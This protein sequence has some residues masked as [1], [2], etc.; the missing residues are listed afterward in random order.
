MNTPWIGRIVS[1]SLSMQQPENGANIYLTIDYSLQ[2]AVE[3]I[4]KKYYYELRPDDI[5]V[6]IMDPFDGKIKAMA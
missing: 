6:I 1:S 2:K 3:D 5:S 4:I